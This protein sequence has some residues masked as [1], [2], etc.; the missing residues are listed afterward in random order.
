MCCRMLFACGDFPTSKLFDS[1]KLM[2]LNRNEEHE[3]NKNNCNFI[4]GDGWG[5]VLGKDGRFTEFSKNLVECWKDP[6]FPQ[7]Y[8]SEG[9]FV[10]IH[11]RRR[12]PGSP[13]RLS[14]TQPF[15]CKGW[16]F[17]HNGTVYDYEIEDVSD[18]EQLFALLLSKLEK[19]TDVVGAITDALKEIKS[20]S[21]LN[22]I[23]FNEKQVY[24]LRKL[25]G[26][27][28][29]KEYPKYYAMK[30]LEDENYLIAS[31]ERLVHWGGD[32]KE[33]DNNTLLRVSISD[34][35]VEEIKI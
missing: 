29:G 16:C 32:W 28:R 3:L 18:S 10:V 22:F 31:S 20:Y 23:L 24:I 9:D 30:Y 8:D 21:S 5:I 27:K 1:F 25:G 19:E 7:Y 34:R 15:G 13:L 35:K 2:A 33:L 6:R 12:S 26:T 4:H 14:Y 17:C 11:A